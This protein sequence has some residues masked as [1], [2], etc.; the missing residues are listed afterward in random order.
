[1]S[2]AAASTECP[3][4]AETV[5]VW[6]PLV[7]IFHWSLVLAFFSAYALGDDGGEWHQIFGFTVLGLVTFRLL[8]GLVGTQYARF[9]SFVPSPRKLIAY[10][11][12][13]LAHREA[14]YLGHN[15]AGAAMI[16]ALL[17]MLIGTGSTGWLLTTDAY[18]GSEAMEEVHE[19]LANGTLLLVGL[20]VA[21]VV[22]SSLRHR[23]NL[24][25]AMMSGRKRRY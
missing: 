24:L 23:E 9:T 5:R 4:Q 2:P 18:W 3:A 17:L 8:W 13:L 1:M 16:V 22:F 12:D 15:P 21:G 11:Q 7:R 14:R 10:L 6:D 20:H 25:R 19:A